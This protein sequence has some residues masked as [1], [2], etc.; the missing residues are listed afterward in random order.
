MKLKQFT[1]MAQSYGGDLAR[2]PLAQ[3]E[4]ARRLLAI[5]SEAASILA[6]A[7][8]LDNAIGAASRH[9]VRAF[10]DPAG[11]NAALARLRAGVDARITAASMARRR[12]PGWAGA[13]ILGWAPRALCGGTRG[14]GLATSGAFAVM[15]GLVLGMMLVSPPPSKGPQPGT[16]VLTAIEPEPI[17][18]FMAQ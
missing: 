3:Q 11:H 15:A 7:R 2:W 10:A 5:S 13:G 12:R 14:L 6:E 9:E 8:R 18:M 4:D 17:Q 16:S 1:D